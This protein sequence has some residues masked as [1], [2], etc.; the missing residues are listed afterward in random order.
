MTN[1]TLSICVSDWIQ[2]NSVSQQ[3]I[4]SLLRLF[5]FAALT[6]LIKPPTGTSTTLSIATVGVFEDEERLELSTIGLTSHRSAI[7]LFIHFVVFNF[8]IPYFP[9]LISYSCWPGENRTHNPRIKSSVH[10]TVELRT[11][12]V[13]T[14]GFEPLT[15]IVSG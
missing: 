2:T 9:F 14:K 7:E 12:V 1:R 4:Y 8:P 10:L 3:Q 5:N 15:T 11:N 6:I 13:M